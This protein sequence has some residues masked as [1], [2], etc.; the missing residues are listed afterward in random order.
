MRGGFVIDCYSQNS[1]THTCFRS[2]RPNE[3]KCQLKISPFFPILWY[4]ILI[5]HAIW[6]M[7]IPGQQEYL[8]NTSVRKYNTKACI[9]RHM[10]KV[11]HIYYLHRLYCSKLL[12]ASVMVCI[13]GETLI[14]CLHN[15]F[16]QCTFVDNSVQVEGARDYGHTHISEV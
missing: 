1:I 9:N 16:M 11:T 4:W 7:Q 3:R 12:G 8:I 15:L 14:N 5:T 2:C 10:H 13:V 6:L